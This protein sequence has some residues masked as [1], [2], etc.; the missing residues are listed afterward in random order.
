MT[1]QEVGLSPVQALL[2]G[3]LVQ[4]QPHDRIVIG[5][6]APCQ[7]HEVAGALEVPYPAVHG[8]LEALGAIRALAYCTP[9]LLDPRS[10]S[11][12]A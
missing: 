5:V 7:L 1:A 11:L 3:V 2:S 12:V 8:F 6:D 9:E 4:L 10:W